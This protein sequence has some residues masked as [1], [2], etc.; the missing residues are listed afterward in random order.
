MTDTIKN[1]AQILKSELDNGDN[2]QID[3]LAMADRIARK[4]A[5]TLPAAE[6]KKFLKMC[7]LTVLK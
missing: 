4:I 2:D 7:R 1:T 5:Q 6:G 3:G